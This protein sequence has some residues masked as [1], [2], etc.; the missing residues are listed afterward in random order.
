MTPSSKL[1]YRYLTA[2]AALKTIESGKLRVGRIT[3]FNDPFEWRP[4]IEGVMPQYRQI[5]THIMDS[6]INSLNSQFGIICMSESAKEPVLWSHYANNHY[7]VALEFDHILNDTVKEIRYTNNRPIINTNKLNDDV[8]M[9]P[10]VDAMIHQKSTGWSY[11]QE[12]RV[13]VDLSS[14]TISGGHY[15]LDIPE[16][17]LKRIILG[18]RCPLEEEYV[19]IALKKSGLDDC[20]VV[21]AEM[22]EHSYSVLSES[23]ETP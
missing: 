1:L 6:I 10:I 12:Y 17:F 21:R 3:E 14:C 20:S 23:I 13:H 16:D 9:R 2:D 8:Y 5:A 15:F 4:G 19:K 22:D 18:Y 7:G 11:E